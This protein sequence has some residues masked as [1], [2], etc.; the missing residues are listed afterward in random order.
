MAVERVDDHLAFVWVRQMHF[1]QEMPGKADTISL[2]TNLAGQLQPQQR[3]AN[4]NTPAGTQ[5]HMQIAVVGV[6][7][8]VGV[9]RKTHFFEKEL[10]EDA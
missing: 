4:R 8:V 2:Q 1:H 3:Q 10:V 5:H 6:V 7:V 9:A